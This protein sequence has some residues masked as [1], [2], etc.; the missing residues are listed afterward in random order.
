MTQQRLCIVLLCYQVRRLACLWEPII[1]QYNQGVAY[2]TPF[3]MLQ[4]SLIKQQEPAV[5][6]LH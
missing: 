6:Y 5:T 3:R 2:F 4:C 1:N